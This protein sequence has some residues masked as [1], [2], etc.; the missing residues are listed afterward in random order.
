MIS[1]QSYCV[2]GLF[3]RNYIFEF[4]EEHDLHKNKTLQN[5]T[6]AITKMIMHVRV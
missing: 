6:S 1:K 5:T 2:M 3:Q 4:F